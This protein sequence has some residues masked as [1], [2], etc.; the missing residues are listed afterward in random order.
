MNRSGNI[1][2][3]SGGRRAQT[4]QFII[5]TGII[6]IVLGM[7]A[8]GWMLLEDISVPDKKMQEARGSLEDVSTKVGSLAENCWKRAGRGSA[9]RSI[10]CYRVRLR[11]PRTVKREEV[12]DKL[13]D[14]PESRLEMEEPLDGDMAKISYNPDTGDIEVEPF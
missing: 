9:K 3:R 6:V 8:G 5:L 13:G 7:I 4:S 10:D 1:K 14:L 2:E 12:V 11:T